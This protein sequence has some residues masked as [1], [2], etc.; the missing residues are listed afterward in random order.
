[1]RSIVVLPLS[2]KQMYSGNSQNQCP[3]KKGETA[4]W[5]PLHATTVVLHITSVLVACVMMG[6]FW[7]VLQDLCVKRVFV[8]LVFC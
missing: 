8:S 5:E 7:A 3:C 1:M 6:P 4:W 2:R